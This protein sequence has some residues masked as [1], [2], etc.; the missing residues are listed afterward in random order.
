ML[1]TAEEAVRTFMSGLKLTFDL[2]TETYFTVTH[3][4]FEMLRPK[5]PLRNKQII[6]RMKTYLLEEGRCGNCSN[7][8]LKSCELVDYEKGPETVEVGLWEP[9]LGLHLFDDLFPHF[10]GALRGRVLTVASNNV[11]LFTARFLIFVTQP[12]S[13]LFWKF[14]LTT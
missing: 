14:Y 3:E 12:R 4:E 5:P 7:W 8:N 6:T 10:S 13:E 9:K 1:C 2:E 11:S